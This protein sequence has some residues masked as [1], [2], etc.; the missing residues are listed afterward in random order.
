LSSQHDLISYVVK[1][2]RSDKIAIKEN[3]VANEETNKDLANHKVETS[4]KFNKMQDSIIN[5]IH[6]KPDGSSANHDMSA[7]T[8]FGNIT[9]DTPRGGGGGGGGSTTVNKDP[10]KELVSHNAYDS[11]VTASGGGGDGHTLPSITRVLRRK[12]MPE[13]Y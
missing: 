10:L 7:R 3:W 1:E 5:S 13:V 4:R 6:K 11:P 8:L 2:Q 12:P 9:G